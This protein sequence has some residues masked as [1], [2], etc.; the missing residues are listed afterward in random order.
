[1]LRRKPILDG[2][3][4]RRAS[5]DDASARCVH[6][7]GEAVRSDRRHVQSGSAEFDGGQTQL[8]RSSEQTLH[9]GISYQVSR[10]CRSV[11]AGPMKNLCTR[12]VICFRR[13]CWIQD[14]DLIKVAGAD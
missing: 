9:R 14:F 1:M 12:I 8:G 2:V 11:S 13:Q 10:G 4:R 6:C 3:C 5:F 7:L